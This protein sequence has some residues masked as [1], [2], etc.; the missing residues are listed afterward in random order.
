MFMRLFHGPHTCWSAVDRK[1][2]ARYSRERL[3]LL[4][5]EL[6]HQGVAYPINPLLC[7][8]PAPVSVKVIVPDSIASHSREQIAYFGPGGLLRRHAYTVDI[9]GG[10]AGLNYA[11]DYRSVDGIVVPT[12]RRVY[13]PD[14]NNQKISEPVLVAIDIRD[15]AFG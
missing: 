12:K 3:L 10:A 14:A 9:M 7:G 13:T 2:L 4:T 5:L 1:P 11:T 6:N 15:I 8:E